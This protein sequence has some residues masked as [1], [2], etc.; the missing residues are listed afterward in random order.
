MGTAD[1]PRDNYPAHWPAARP[2]TR[3]AVRTRNPLL[4]PP[5]R[6][7]RVVT[8]L[9]F[10]GL[11]TLGMALAV[12]C[13]GV[14]DRGASAERA[15]SAQRHRLAAPQSRSRT[16]RDVVPVALFGLTGLV[17]LGAGGCAGYD[18]WS[19]RQHA[20]DWDEEWLRFDRERLG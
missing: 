6:R 16:V 17:V 1:A 15:Q 8:R 5:T 12:L 13:L 4:R 2:W 14:F 7:E 10:A 18:A 9:A 11:V 20:G 3:L 19:L